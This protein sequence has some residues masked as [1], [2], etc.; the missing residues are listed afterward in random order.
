MNGIGGLAGVLLVTLAVVGCSGLG[1]SSSGPESPSIAAPSIAAASA[2]ASTVVSPRPSPRPSPSPVPS[3]SP[4]ASSV[5][6][7][8]APA[9]TVPAADP[10]AVVAN[11][12][13][14][15]SAPDFSAHVGVVATM[16]IGAIPFDLDSST[17]LAGV[18][19]GSVTT[20]AVAGQ[21]L[22]TQV[23]AIGGKTYVRL[24]TGDW[25]IVPGAGDPNGV[26][27]FAGLEPGDLTYLK[28]QSV[29]GRPLHRLR[30]DAL[31]ID[32]AKVTTSRIENVV[33]DVATFE[34][35]V[36]EAG[37][38]VLGYYDF[39]GSARIDGTR[40]PLTIDANYRFSKVG[41]PI[42]IEAPI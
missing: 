19:F 30:L 21:S 40:Q 28:T 15:A 12:V 32:P 41:E 5:A 14:L 29:G 34:L 3:P 33:V 31:P 17:D 1:L 9:S 7:P 20:L 23:I 35:L 38:P 25:R 42:P 8:S 26:N 16:E 37:R 11:F 39:A 10:D 6:S 22:R 36:D 27:P 24:G 2:V 18:D 4:A 13:S